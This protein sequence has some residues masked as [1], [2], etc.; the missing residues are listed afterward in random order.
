MNRAFARTSLFA[1]TTLAPLIGSSL[2]FAQ[3]PTFTPDHQDGIY[4]IGERVG[5]TVALPA[6]ATE[7]GPYTYTIRKNGATV[8]GTGAVTLA[9]NHGRIETSL[10]E[11]AMLV[12]EVKPPAGATG[13]GNVS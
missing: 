8:L 10:R 11:P 5:W 3:Q 13:F 9:N 12:V 4:A 6:G 2:A 1:I 7:T